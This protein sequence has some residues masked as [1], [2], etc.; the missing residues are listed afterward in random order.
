MAFC[1]AWRTMGRIMMTV[2][3]NANAADP[4]ELCLIRKRGL[5]QSVFASARGETWP[6]VRRE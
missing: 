5:R 2:K 3:A 1:L 4:E 6:K